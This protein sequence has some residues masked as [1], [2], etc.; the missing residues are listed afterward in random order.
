ML[1]STPQNDLGSNFT[2]NFKINLQIALKSKY[3]REV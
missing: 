3:N 1:S 2:H